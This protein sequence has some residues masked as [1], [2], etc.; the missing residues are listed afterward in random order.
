[1]SFEWLPY[2]IMLIGLIAS[3]AILLRKHLDLLDLFSDVRH[4]S[5][6]R[7]ESL[8]NCMDQIRHLQQRLRDEE[9][10]EDEFDDRYT[11]PRQPERDPELP[12]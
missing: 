4:E 11:D 8:V 7:G 2:F 1:M 5:E 12:F 3:Q 9:D 6:T 10:P